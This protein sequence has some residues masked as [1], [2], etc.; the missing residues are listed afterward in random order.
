MRIQLT[1]LAIAVTLASVI[2]GSAMAQDKIVSGTVTYL[3]RSML[4][5]GA[6]LDVELVDASRADTSSTR[7]SSRR[8]AI[9]HV[10]FSFELAYDSLLIDERYS[11][12]IQARISVDEKL[13]YINTT[14]YPAL[15]RNAPEQVNVVVDLLPKPTSPGLEG[16]DWD[17]YEMTGRMLVSEKRPSISFEPDG[18]VGID[19]SC[20]KFH[21]PIEVSGSSVRFSD[22]MAGTMRAC[23]SPYD[24]LEQDILAILP[25]VTG[26]LQ[27]GNQLALTNA[28]GV[29]VL[30]LSRNN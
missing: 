22:K 1:I 6:I 18:I 3:N 5:P 14:R 8:Y 10:P 11:Y 7:I 19:T 17:V 24:K 25:Q 13:M 20:N 23:A 2:S 29:T 30:R 4:P 9:D 28:A 15:T 27:S 21:G 16:S 12:A 26:W